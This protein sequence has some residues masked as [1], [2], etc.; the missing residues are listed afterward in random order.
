MPC[1]PFKTADGTGGFMCGRRE[2]SRC[3][4][5]CGRVATLLCDYPITNE[6]GVYK[7][8]DRPLC[9]SCAHEV[10]TDR[11]YCRVHREY[12]LKREE[13]E[14]DPGEVLRS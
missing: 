5:K 4:Q 3:I 13:A 9:A 6:P 11:H 1:I 8:C 12:H 14:N 2:P 10:G 7:T